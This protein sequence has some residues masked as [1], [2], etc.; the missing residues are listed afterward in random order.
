[1]NRLVTHSKDR[2]TLL[3]HVNRIQEK[4]NKIPV[5]QITKINPNSSESVQ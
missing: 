3:N 1:M 2:Y 5:G 4:H